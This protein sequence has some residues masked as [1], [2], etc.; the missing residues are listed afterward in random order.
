MAD[1]DEDYATIRELMPFTGRRVID[2]TQ[3][4][5]VD[6]ICGQ[7]AFFILH[8]DDGSW[9][10]VV[11]TDEGPSVYVLESAPNPERGRAS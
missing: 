1:S 7:P 2:V 4:D 11:F 10:R 6:W 5:E 3:H 9:L 8:F